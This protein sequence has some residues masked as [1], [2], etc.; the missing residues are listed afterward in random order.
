[1]KYIWKNIGSF[2][3]DYTKIFVLLIITIAAST[4]IIHLS[5]GMF[6]E[7]KDRK[8]LSRMGAKEVVLRLKSSYAQKADA[9]SG[10]DGNM[11]SSEDLVYQTYEKRDDVQD[12][13]VADLKRFARK[14]DEETAD[15]LLNIHTGVLQ[16]DYRFETDFLIAD[17]KI[18]N[19]GDYGFD[20]LYNFSFGDYHTTNIFQYGRYFTDREYAEGK[21]VCIM[22]GFQKN[23]RGDYLKENLPDDGKV[24]IGG[25]E[26]QIIGLQ[27]GIG[28]GYIP[29]TS[30]DED[31]ILLDDIKL[32]FQDN[33]S[34]REI[35]LINEAAEQCFGGM[36]ASNYEVEE[37]EDNSYLY[38]T[39]LF[40]VFVV[41]LVAAFNF[42]ALYH[43]SVTTR[44]RTLKIF[45]ICGLSHLKSIWLY[46]GECSILSAG[47]YLVTLFLFHFLLM[48]FLAGRMKIFD[49]HYQAGVYLTLFL[50]YFISSFLLQYV[51]IAWNLKKKMIR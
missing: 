49:F 38:N 11:I 36:A 46:L 7:Y 45:R 20:S 19:S 4:L 43:Y 2:V 17:G 42:C 34:L 24:L 39:I 9:A 29:I 41:S 18:V 44:Q 26:Y 16:G 5:Y 15:K 40:L 25:R 33:I 1:M 37:T 31:S 13:T 10:L 3:K 14:L 22:Y 27:N 8:E 23:L 32:Q 12:V 35:G 21:P 30:V 47:T 51:M 50:I 28:T 48:P 6:R